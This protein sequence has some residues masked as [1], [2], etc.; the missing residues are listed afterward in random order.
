MPRITII[1][2]AIITIARPSVCW[3]VLGT[4]LCGRVFLCCEHFAA[5]LNLLDLGDSLK[6]DG[7]A[8]EAM[9]A[10]LALEDGRVFRGTGFGAP[11]E[12]GG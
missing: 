8:G 6:T 4:R 7:I 3:C 12:R 10:M 1:I 2:T 11:V 5:P 9:Q